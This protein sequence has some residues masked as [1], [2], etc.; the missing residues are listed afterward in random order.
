[1]RKGR[2]DIAADIEAQ[3]STPPFPAAL[4]YVWH[5]WTRLRRRLAP[6]ANGAA[7]FT[8][9]ELDAFMRRTGT[10]LDP[11]DIA[12]LEDL[13]DLF[14]E[15]MRKDAADADRQQAIKDGLKGAGR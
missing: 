6:G 4:T 10:V 12:L 3:L 8:W 9:A 1:M 14:L 2:E 15:H 5:A 7:P 11:R 13:D